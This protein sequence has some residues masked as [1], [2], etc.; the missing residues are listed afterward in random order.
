M[1]VDTSPSVMILPTTYFHHLQHAE[2]YR[3]T[4]MVGTYFRWVRYFGVF[5]SLFLLPLWLLFALNPSLLP[6]NLEFIG[7]RDQGSLPLF[8]Q[9]L[10][11]EIGIDMMRMA[12][13][14]TPAPLATAMG[15]IAAIL[16]GEI[17]VKVGLF[18]PEVILYV[19]VA[20]IGTFATPSYELSLANR[21][22]RIFFLIAVAMFK[23]TGLLLVAT[24]LF[25]HLSR[26][27]SLYTP[28]LSPFVPFRWN[29]CLNLLV[30]KPFLKRNP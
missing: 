11:A 15:L 1:I 26:K 19:A 29:E 24:W 8:L 27:R 10:F 17:A 7:P 22:M 9:F 20:A 30:R 14:H 16:I 6:E 23:V 12:A 13:I 18:V 21:I 3:N 25:V 5:A 2:E 28:Y 4:P